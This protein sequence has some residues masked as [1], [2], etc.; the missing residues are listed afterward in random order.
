[1]Q[2]SDFISNSVSVILVLIFL[3]S[4]IEAFFNP[5]KHITS[6]MYFL[7]Y[8]NEVNTQTKTKLDCVK[9]T[10]AQSQPKQK[11]KKNTK[12]ETNFSDELKNECN[13]AMKAIGVDAKQRTYLLK[14]I[15]QIHNPKTVEEFLRKA[16]V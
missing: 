5:K 15:F 13:L 1:M 4:F 14:T 2:T 9:V 3:S 11:P 6:P 10:A 8:D 16:F 12:P 7:G